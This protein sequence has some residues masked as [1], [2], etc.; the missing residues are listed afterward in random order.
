MRLLKYLGS[1]MKLAALLTS[2][3]V[4]TAVCVVL[5]S[6]YSVLRKQPSFVNV[7]FGAKIAQVRARQQDAFRF[8]RFVPSPSW[9]LKAWETSD[10]E[11]CAT[12]GLDA[13]V[14]VRMIVF[15]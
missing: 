10:E 8:D 13:V 5:F 12:G 4:N 14:F 15:R 6:L 11:I 9:I 3:G 1:E 7:Y 2:A